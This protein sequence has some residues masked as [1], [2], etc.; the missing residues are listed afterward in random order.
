MGSPTGIALKALPRVRLRNR[1]CMGRGGLS[2]CARRRVVASLARDAAQIMV[3][4]HL[5]N[6]RSER[7]DGSVDTA[8]RFDLVRESH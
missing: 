5:Q 6:G 7:G 1:R 3:G 2:A 8:K 4:D